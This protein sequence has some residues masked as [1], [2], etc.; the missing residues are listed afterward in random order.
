MFNDPDALLKSIDG[1]LTFPGGEPLSK[2]AMDVEDAMTK[3]IFASMLPAVWSTGTSCKSTS[4][5]SSLLYK[6]KL[7]ICSSSPDNDYVSARG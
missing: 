5:T 4:E 2:A 7:T 3:F 6:H 1:G